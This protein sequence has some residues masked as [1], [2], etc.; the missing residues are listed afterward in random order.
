MVCKY[1]LPSCKIPFNLLTAYVRFCVVNQD[2]ITFQRSFY[3]YCEG[4][5]SARENT[6]EKKTTLRYKHFKEKYSFLSEVPSNS[7]I[8]ALGNRSLHCLGIVI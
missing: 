4:K 1:F 8:S 7:F 3:S 5:G 2:M 6:E